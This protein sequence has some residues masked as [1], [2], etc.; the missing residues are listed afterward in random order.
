MEQIPTQQFAPGDDVETPYDVEAHGL[1][2]VAAGLG[3]AAL[4]AGGAASVAQAAASSPALPQQS[5]VAVS[6]SADGA[7]DAAVAQARSTRDQAVGV[8][9]TTA[10]QVVASTLTTADQVVATTLTTADSGIAAAEQLGHSATRGASLV[11]AR[12]TRMAEPRI[13]R[14]IA[15]GT[16]AVSSA[17]QQV[18]ALVTVSAEAQPDGWVTLAV[19]SHSTDAAVLA[20]DTWVMF[21]VA[22]NN[23]GRAQL[24][25][26][27]ASTTLDARALHGQVITVVSEA[28]A[29]LGSIL[30]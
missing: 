29:A 14:A 18:A 8:A 12:V 16:A 10:D 11:A 2:E 23:V 15:Q 17:Q 7:V 25:G 24:S 3:A 9:F 21:Q 20:D 1:K 22:G 5:V 26:G 30:L 13:D 6:T 27:R 28:G 19:T 4:L